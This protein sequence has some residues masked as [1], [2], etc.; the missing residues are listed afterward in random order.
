MQSSTLAPSRR[1][2]VKKGLVSSYRQ[3][4]SAYTGQRSIA[5]TSKVQS[6]PHSPTFSQLLSRK[7]GSAGRVAMPTVEFADAKAAASAHQFDGPLPPRQCS[8]VAHK[9]KHESHDQGKT[10][11]SRGRR[12]N[13]P[14]GNAS[15]R[16][17]SPSCRRA[18]DRPWCRSVPTASD[19]RR[20]RLFAP[21]RHRQHDRTGAP[22]VRA[23]NQ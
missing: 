13:R 22:N 16:S 23:E 18:V 10:S 15:S 3:W 17:A 21:V 14:V 12:A 1:S 4:E 11:A 19:V 6:K 9:I 2:R 20:L 5:V 7:G 8:K